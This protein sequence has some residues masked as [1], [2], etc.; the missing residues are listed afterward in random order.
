M[1]GPDR[2]TRIT[3]VR[4]DE[5]RRGQRLRFRCTAG[6]NWYRVIDGVRPAHS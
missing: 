6:N 4:P 3:G 2:S 1:S 5:Q